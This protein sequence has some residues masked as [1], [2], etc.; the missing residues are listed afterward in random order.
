MAT[1][2]STNYTQT[3]ETVIRDAL[4]K[5]EALEEGEA[6]TGEHTTSALR[7]LNRIIKRWNARQMRWAR[8]EAVLF[9]NADQQ[10]YDLP[11]DNCGINEFGYTRLNGAHST[12]DTVLTVDATAPDFPMLGMA[13]SAHIGIELEDGTRHWTTISSVGSSTS[14]TIASGLSGDAADDATVFWYTTEIERPVRVFNARRGP[15]SGS[16][17]AIDMVAR[18]EYLNQP[19]K[20]ASSTPVLAHYHPAIT[21]GKLYVWPTSSTCTNVLRFT[22]Q[23]TI[24]DAD[25]VSNNLD[26]PEEAID[27]LIYELAAML[28]PEYQLPMEKRVMLKEEATQLLE[29]LDSFDEDDTYIQLVPR[30]G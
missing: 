14:V 4:Y 30:H 8:R 13:S 24:E 28:A 3:V 26:M 25:S 7:Q 18:D 17:V 10:V 2:G 21:T 15:Y 9:L 22:Y 1:S 6:I 29:E 19:N 11:G 5:C 27:A 12:S 20:T 16:E 23:R